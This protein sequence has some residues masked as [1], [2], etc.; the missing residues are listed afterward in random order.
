MFIFTLY[1]LNIA[2]SYFTHYT[3]RSEEP[4]SFIEQQ[5][6]RVAAEARAEN[7][8]NDYTLL[9]AELATLHTTLSAAQQ[10][11]DEISEENTRLKTSFSTWR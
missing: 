1:T 10:Q 4:A 5:A 8:K 3:L 6:L 9:S 7:I 11:R 2:H